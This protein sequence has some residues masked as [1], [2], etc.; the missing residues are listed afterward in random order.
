VLAY[1]QAHF[2][3]LVSMEQKDGSK[4]QGKGVPSLI[5]SLNEK[6]YINKVALPIS[7][8]RRSKTM[9]RCVYIKMGLNKPPAELYM[10]FNNPGGHSAASQENKTHVF[11]LTVSEDSVFA[12]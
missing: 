5:P 9:S 12:Q 1:D 11:L 4:E 6:R 3:A 2:S 10:L 8:G 7:P